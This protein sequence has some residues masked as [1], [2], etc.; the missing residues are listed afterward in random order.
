[1][2]DR[3]SLILTYLSNID[4]HPTASAR[5]RLAGENANGDPAWLATIINREIRSAQKI[6]I[7]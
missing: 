1:M 4:V 5:A 2:V 6:F 3:E 7:I